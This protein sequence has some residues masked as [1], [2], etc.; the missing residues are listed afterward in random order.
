MPRFLNLL[1]AAALLGFAASPAQ[2]FNLAR[3]RWPN[4]NVPMHLQLGPVSAP[5]LDGATSWGSAA[6][7]ALTAW[8]SNLTNV[9]FTVVR[10]STAPIARSNAINNVFWSGTV[11]G[12][13]WDGRT[14]AITL[15]SYN[16]QTSRYLE[17]DV[18][19]NNTLQWNSYRG[20]L[21]Q[22]TGGATL[23]DFRRVAL[24]EFG[25]ALGLNHP[26]DIGQNVPAIMNAATSNTDALTADDIAG[27]KAIYDNPN[28]VPQP[29]LG[30][31]GSIGFSTA[32]TNL[33]LRVGQVRNDGDAASRTIRLELW[34]M[35]QRYDN[36]LPAGSRNLGIY[37][38]PSPLAAQGVINNVNVNTPYTAPPAGSYFVALLLT[39]FTGASGSG[40]ATRDFIEFSNPLNVGNTTAAPAITTQP[41]S[42]T[43]EV[44]ATATF[45]VAATGTLP[46]N[47]QWR[48]NGTVVIGATGTSLTLSNV[49]SADAGAYT[50]TVTNGFGTVTSS[51]ATLTVNVPAVARLS[52]VSVRSTAGSG[53]QTLIVGFNVGGSGSKSILLR[54][55]GPTLAIFG[56]SGAVADPQLRLFNSGGTQINL[57]DN[58]GGGTALANAFSSVGAFGL[59]ATSLDAA[60]LLSL[61]AGSYS[62]QLTSSGA[63]GIALV[64]G[65]DADAATSTARLTNVSVRSLVG[66]GA[67]ILI[68][69]FAIAG[70]SSKTLLVRGVGPTLGTFGVS[71]TLVD[72]QL[73]LFNS[74]GIQI[75]QNDNWGGGAALATAFTS[76]GAFALPA[77]SRDAVLLVT[78][79]PGAYTAQLSGVASGVGVALVEVYEVP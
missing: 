73:Q 28:N 12:D 77:T 63:T 51:P 66:T 72:P 41:A 16:P 32:G 27:G 30:M 24:H 2:A 37:T 60:L 57:N 54:G 42:V 71:D 13:A 31:Q 1:L 10:D 58:W 34:A 5:L 46:I 11:Y 9:Q 3:E 35:S 55:I 47:Y 20:A 23:N 44:G 14:L 75:N 45:T 61:S 21:R 17:T 8:N 50:V 74:G 29:L 6:E 65:Y 53:A 69:G 26:D 56:V 7:S 70:N 52:N 49:Q 18:I 33:N 62:A 38:F 19:F 59:S 4:G 36:G 15:S 76:V 40:Y 67:N 22:G 39:E 43:V 68:V 79:Q 78:L 64:E 48:K 25:H